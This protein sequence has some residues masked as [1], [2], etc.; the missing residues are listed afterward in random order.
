M[1][2]NPPY[3]A[4]AISMK[5]AAERRSQAFFNSTGRLAT[6]E[7]VFASTLFGNRDASE[8]LSSGLVEAARSRLGDPAD[9]EPCHL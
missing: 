1:P 7:A 4:T 5:S 8:R 3:A 9:L 6:E 2:T